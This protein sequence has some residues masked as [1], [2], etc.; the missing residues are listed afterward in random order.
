M[1]TSKVVRQQFLIVVLMF[2]P[3]ILSMIFWNQVPEEV[4]IHWNAKGE[5]DGWGHKAVNLLFLPCIMVFLNGIFWAIPYVDPKKNVEEFLPTLR[6]YQIAINLFMLLVYGAVLAISLG[7]PLKMEILVP[8]ALYGLFIVLGNSFGKLR[9][10]HFVGIRVPWTLNDEE[11]WV[12][13]HRMAGKLWVGASVIAAGLHILLKGAFFLPIL[14]TY[15][16]FVVGG[17]FWYSYRL[18]KEKE[19]KG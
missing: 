13:T 10:N 12:K 5:P 11:N 15:L 3:F 6:V 2:T 7:K 14:F 17:P 19:H 9:P 8:L 1:D 16:A 4:P 18:F